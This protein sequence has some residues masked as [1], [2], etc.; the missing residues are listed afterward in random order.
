MEQTE[1]MSYFPDT[2]HG[3][4]AKRQ[5][6]TGAAILC[7]ALAATVWP[8]LIWV[9]VVIFALGVPFLAVLALFFGRRFFRTAGVFYRWITGA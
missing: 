3:Q 7:Y 5:C 1:P 8:N 4:A 6:Y 9:T 2:P